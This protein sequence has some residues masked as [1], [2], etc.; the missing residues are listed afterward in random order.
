MKLQELVLEEGLSITKMPR[1]EKSIQIE[2]SVDAIFDKLLGLLPRDYKHREVLAHAIIGS[3]VEKGNI[4]YIYNALNG[5]TNDIDFEVG[6]EV[7]CSNTKRVEWY[8]ANLEEKDGKII[9]NNDVGMPDYKANW[10]MRRVAIGKCVIKEINLYADEKLTVEYETE[11]EYD[12]NRAP[13]KVTSYVSHKNCTKV[14]MYPEPV[15]K[16]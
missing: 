13:Q 10:K 7:I 6:Q 9:P 5:F 1:F 3:A 15:S 11:N 16:Q 8:D 14:P 4:G 12:R 2:V